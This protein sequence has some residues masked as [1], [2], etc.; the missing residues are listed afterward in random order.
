MVDQEVDQT[1]PAERVPKASRVRA[2]YGGGIVLVVAALV[3]GGWLAFSGTWRAW[4]AVGI[5]DGKRVTRADL[6]QHL[7]FLLK[8]GR[9]RPEA[10][11]DP[12]RRQEAERSALN[13]LITRRLL[14][15]EAARLKIPLGPGEE[16]LAFNKAHGGQPGEAKLAEAAKKAGED[17]ERMREEVRRQL[18]LTRLADK[19]T[20]G[21]AVDEADVAKYYEAHREAF[22]V[23]GPV[24]LR[25]LI[26]DS[27]DEAER[28]RA[29][30]LRGADFA[31]L[32][33]EHSKGGA[34]ESGG[35]MG[36]VDTRMLPASIGQ[37][38]AAIPRTGIT[39]VI[40]ARGAFYLVRVD[41]R[42]PSRQVPLA[43]VKEHVREVLTAERKQ[44]KFAEWLEERR[45]A[46]RI[47]VYL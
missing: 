32:V 7:D 3:F 9:V 2:L 39:P 24:H 16:D 22:T 34:R 15:A 4:G 42:Q 1:A 19:V 40:E 27:R 20:E 11:A 47:E 35:D 31:A 30:A 29:Q 18:L 21:V 8:Q 25:L 38:V 13:D 43:E 46:A 5:I 10:L 26:V 23:P 36:W 28:L 45:R 14:L 37:E 41:G 17:L 33:R 6:E 44:A 12:A